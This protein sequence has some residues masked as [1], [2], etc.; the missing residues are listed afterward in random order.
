MICVQTNI[1]TMYTRHNWPG[2]GWDTHAYITLCRFIERESRVK[3]SAI[4]H[5]IGVLVC[6]T[7]WTR[8]RNSERK[9]ERE[10]EGGKEREAE[11]E[12]THLH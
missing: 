2:S 1:G 8:G 12:I 4:D 7:R 5:I 11:K 9:R 6:I 3:I 10:R